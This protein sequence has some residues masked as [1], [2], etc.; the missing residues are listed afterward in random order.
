M[1]A[2]LKTKFPKGWDQ[3][4]VQRVIDYYDT[5]SDEDA[6][7]EM[8]ESFATGS[9]TLMEVPVKLVPQIRRLIAKGAARS[10]P[11]PRGRSKKPA[12]RS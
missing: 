5:Q 4:R 2:K 8:E 7:R 3:T 6:V 12:M 10:R 9:S 11:A 1:K